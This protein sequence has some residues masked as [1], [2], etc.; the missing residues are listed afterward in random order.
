MKNQEYLSTGMA[1]QLCR[2]FGKPLTKTALYQVGLKRGFAQKSVD[3]FHW[4]FQRSGL[5]NYL[6]EGEETPPEGWITI[7]TVS[8]I[9][10]LSLSGAYDFVKRNQLIVVSYGSRNIKYVEEEKA[11][12]AWKNRGVKRNGINE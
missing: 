8:Q 3:G 6:N 12:N 7:L 5:E 1:L 9:T 10:G 4:E 2:N 11:M